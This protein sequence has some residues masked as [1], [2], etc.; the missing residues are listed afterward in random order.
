MSLHSRLV[1]AFLLWIATMS[2]ASA[3]FGFRTG[4]EDFR[5]QEFNGGGS[6]LLEESGRRYRFGIDWRIPLQRPEFL[7]EFQGS[8]YVGQVDY[9]GQACTLSGSCVPF[10]SDTTYSGGQIEALLVSRFGQIAGGELIVGGGIDNWR[11]DIRG[12]SGVSGVAEDWTVFYLLGGGGAHWRAESARFNLRG[13]FKYPFYTYE[14]PDSTPVTLEPKGRLSFFA[15]FVANFTTAHGPQWGIGVY[16]DSYRFDE[17]DRQRTGSVIVWQ[18]E[19]HQDIFGIYGVI[20]L[21]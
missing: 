9:N 15:R 19:S 11:R 14:D 21:H 3:E 20:Y 18:P 4:V 8:I 7:L 2:S 12:H 17:S 6:R 10:R 5:W 1:S 16:Y 13:G